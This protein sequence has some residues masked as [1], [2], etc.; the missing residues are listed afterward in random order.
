MDFELGTIVVGITGVVKQFGV[1]GKWLILTAVLVG[2]AVSLLQNLVPDAA[3]YV[4][5][6]LVLG[7]TCAG[8]YGVG[9]GAAQALLNGG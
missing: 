1:S 3:R 2:M 5:D 9:K 6:A 4:F 7:L 8:L